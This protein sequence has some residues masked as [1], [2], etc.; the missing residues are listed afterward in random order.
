MPSISDRVDRVEKSL[1]LLEGNEHSSALLS[2]KLGNGE[3]ENMFKL[4]SLASSTTE[5]FGIA[6]NVSILSSSSSEKFCNGD[7][8]DDGTFGPAIC[9]SGI[10]IFVFLDV[11]A[12]FVASGALNT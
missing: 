5:T 3:D 9:V 10:S 2:D 6:D 12:S 11:L 1:R 8:D 4:L 7:D